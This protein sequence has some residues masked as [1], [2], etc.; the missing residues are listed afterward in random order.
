MSPLRSHP[1][2]PLAATALLAALL[3]CGSAQASVL[4]DP[5]LG[6]APGQQGWL[7]AATGSAPR[8][9]SGG[10]LNFDTTAA[11]ATKAGFVRA[12]Q[13]LDSRA[14]MT[15]S[16]TLDVLAESHAS[17]HRAGFSVIMLDDQHQ[18]IELGFWA[19]E[20]WAQSGSDFL[21]A[22]SAAWDTTAGT[23]TDYRLTLQGG[24]YQLL[25]NGSALLS[26]A[27]RDYSSFGAPYATANL[28]F[29]GDDTTSAQARVNLGVVG[30]TSAVPEPASAWLLVLGL[31]LPALRRVRPQRR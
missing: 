15:L 27:M 2:Q 24:T 26:G 31:G 25:A 28:L 21:K 18:G 13:A 1:V 4:Y 16:F 3:A 6:T 23:G 12:D 14:G 20:V 29:L 17:N 8:T 7:F 30:L 22:E 11:M 10:V 19:D 9:V 5:A